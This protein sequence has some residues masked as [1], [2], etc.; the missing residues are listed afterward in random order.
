MVFYS[1]SDFYICYLMTL[2]IVKFYIASAIDKWS[3]GGIM[4]KEG[5]LKYSHFCYYARYINATGD[6]S[7]RR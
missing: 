2:W 3:S 5:T 7:E 4:L 6:T 1:K